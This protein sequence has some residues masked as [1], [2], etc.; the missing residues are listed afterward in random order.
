MLPLL[1]IKHTT[2][3]SQCRLVIYENSPSFLP[4]SILCRFLSN[5]IQRAI[6]DFNYISEFGVKWK[7]LVVATMVVTVA[8]GDDPP[9]SSLVPAICIF[10]DSVVDVGNNNHRVTLLKANFP[11][12][13][14]DFVTHSPTGRFCNGKLAIDFI[15][16]SHSLPV[17]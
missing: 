13:G 15:G 6:M 7:L 8:K 14:R 10:G 4:S 3:H 9:P 1:A 2:L 5:L 12:Y 11:P 17:Y 16:L